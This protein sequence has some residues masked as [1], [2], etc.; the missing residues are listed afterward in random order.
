MIK[1]DQI[2]TKLAAIRAIFTGEVVP[3][4]AAAAPVIPAPIEY[5]LADGVTKVMIS[6]L[7]IGGTITP[8]PVSEGSI[9]LQDGTTIAYDA[10]GTITA[11]T[12]KAA[13]VPVEAMTTPAQM[14]AFLSKFG[15][16]GNTGSSSSDISSLAE[17]V[18]FLFED[19]FSYEIRKKEMDSVLETYN[20]G[21]AASN[22]VIS[23]IFEI[24]EAIADSEVEA[25]AEKEINFEDMTAL[26]Q[27]RSQKKK[28][29][30]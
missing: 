17:I 18:K 5:T 8:L 25:S 7:E 4:V 19:R 24:V 28:V 6:K 13:D 9:I 2:K 11:I 23:G 10:A 29:Y 21:F 26:E 16:G 27:F 1:K 20:A 30:V 14:K 12:P 15:V 3:A 22:K